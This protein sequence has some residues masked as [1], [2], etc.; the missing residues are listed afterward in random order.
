V[1]IPVLLCPRNEE[2]K[3]VGLLGRFIFQE[4]YFPCKPVLVHPTEGKS[5]PVAKNV[6]LYVPNLR[7]CIDLQHDQL[8]FHNYLT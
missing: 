4:I 3:V 8:G 7:Y 5:R 6:W 1:N 2:T